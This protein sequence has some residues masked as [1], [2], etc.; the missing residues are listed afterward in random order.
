MSPYARLGI[1]ASLVVVAG[2]LAVASEQ[3]AFCREVHL[4]LR[5]LVANATGRIVELLGVPAW[6]DVTTVYAMGGYAVRVV[7]A[8]D[9]LAP[10]VLLAGLALALPA[11]GRSWGG[12]FALALTGVVVAWSVNLVR[13]VTVLLL[14][15]RSPGSARWIHEVA[16]PAIVLVA[17]AVLWVLW[18]Q[19][20]VSLL[21]TEAADGEETR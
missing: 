21:E 10:A 5:E 15:T 7:P 9:G 3:A 13:I 8:C 20:S 11:G 17:F 18:L 6:V 4:P 16:F 19:R 12:R 1:R 14:G 2:A